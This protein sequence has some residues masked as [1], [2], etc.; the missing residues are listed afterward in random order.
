MSALPTVLLPGSNLHLPGECGCAACRALARVH[1]LVVCGDRAPGFLDQASQRLRICE[2]EI[3]DL[4]DQVQRP[5]L[6]PRPQVGP[7]EGGSV[8][9]GEEGSEPP[10]PKEPARAA[11]EEGIAEEEK[12]TPEEAPKAKEEASPEKKGT[13]EEKKKKKEEKGEKRRRRRR[14]DKDD[15]SEDEKRRESRSPSREEK[16]K[17]KKSRPGAEEPEPASASSR[18][19]PEPERS[20]IRRDHQ[21]GRGP[22]WVGS[23]PV[24]GHPRWK[25]KNKGVVKRAKQERYNQSRENRRG[26]PYRS[27]QWHQR[28]R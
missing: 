13:V 10:L 5:T 14:K 2:G 4:L 9:A 12:G 11:K 20:P 15:S 16:R 25:G 21:R 22:G 27:E 26:N 1:Y 8:P 6:V 3:R 19:P 28:G 23:V 7:Q 17:E 18:A 24:S